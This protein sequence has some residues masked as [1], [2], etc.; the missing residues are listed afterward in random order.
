MMNPNS[1]HVDEVVRRRLEE[2][3][4]FLRELLDEIARDLAKPLVGREIVWDSDWCG[5]G[6]TLRQ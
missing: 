2:F 4:R 1:R 6:P 5:G 3:D